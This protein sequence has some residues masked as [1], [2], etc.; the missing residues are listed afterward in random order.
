L[1]T[2]KNIRKKF[3]DFFCDKKHSFAKASPVI[4]QNDP[5]LLFTNA[6]MNQ[7]KDVFLG[8]GSRK[9]VRAV[10]S[11]ICI[12]VSGKHNDLEEVGLD[13][14]HLTSF[15]MLGNWS[16][17][18]YYK[19]EA[20]CWAWELFTKEFN[21]PKEIL[22]ASVYESDQESYD[23]WRECTDINSE[24]ILFFGK[25]DNFWEMG[26]VGPC[27]PC[28][29]IH[30]DL[31]P[32]S[33][34]KKEVTGH[35]CEVNG[36]C[37]RYV[38]LWNLVFIQYNRN[39]N[40]D[41]EDL[42]NKH[43]D[44][45]A[46]LERLCA[47]LQ[48][49]I[50]VYNTDLFLPIISKIAALSGVKYENG[51]KGMP[52]RVLA[53]HVRTVTF[54]IAD[55]VLPSNE[56]RGYVIRRLIRRALRYAR[57]LG[58]KEPILF[59][60]VDVVLDVMKEYSLELLERKDFIKDLVKAEEKSFLRT[61]DS[62]L[63][64]FHQV[65]K[66]AKKE[67]EKII[68]GKDAFQLYDTYGF[69]IDL[70]QVMARENDFEV[71]IE[72]FK[73]ELEAQK[74]RSRKARKQVHYDGDAGPIGGEA[75]LVKNEKERLLMARHHTATHLLHSALREVLGDHVVQAGSFVDLDRLRFDFTHFKALTE[76]EKEKVSVKVNEMI[77]K[78]KVLEIFEKPLEEAKD[79]GALSFFGE[80]Y[81][82]IVR[83]VKI[84]DFSMELCGGNH[85]SNTGQI[86][87]FKILQEQ[88]IAAGTRRIEAIAGKENIE[89]Y[90]AEKKK[91]LLARIEQ[92]KNQ[93]DKLVQ[94]ADKYGVQ[95]VSP[96]YTGLEQKEYC[97]LANLETDFIN[98]IK[99]IEKMLT[100]EKS[101]QASKGFEDIY[102][103][104]IEIKDSAVKVIVTKLADFDIPML[105]TL[106]DNLTNKDKNLITVLASEKDGKGYCLVK[107][108]KN[109][110]RSEYQAPA[111]VKIITDIASGGGGGRPDMAQAGGVNPAKISEAFIKLMEILKVS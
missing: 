96:D 80:K 101:K 106:A 37:T 87:G 17:G 108:G 22:Y 32:D 18:D 102:K 95:V 35:K 67:E 33:C 86:E 109:V 23:L 103:N 49:T 16:F 88:A 85:V 61:L 59:K 92:K 98:S 6:G 43:V 57:E 110:D 38:E 10:N 28:S 91:V 64:I 51:I 30:I 81:D 50:S 41:L 74:Q 46:G 65:V 70:T 42:P 40:G 9:Y 76:V 77:K 107:L 55:N 100:Q 11:Q 68:S 7:F 73:K 13:T 72:G 93:L 15:E 90:E 66:K 89:M 79:L 111:I 82:D 21:I 48:N 75:K 53:D 54:A 60:L 45:G 44:T 8:Q 104:A 47:Y 1:I 71:D 52:H 26:E 105:R 27:G 78:N 34:D 2:S 20:I 97:G 63:G 83:V 29:E 69:P 3:I 25:K 12:R 56:G 99:N 84:N 31:G 14:T 19:K 4:P 62:G 5:T 39:L 36:D 58:F 94:Q 24:Q